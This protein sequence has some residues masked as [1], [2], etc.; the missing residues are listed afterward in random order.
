MQDMLFSNITG[1]S[2][3]G[4]V[5]VGDVNFPIETIALKGLQLELAKLTDFPGGYRDLRPPD[6]P[7]GLEAAAPGA[8][9]VRNVRE[10]V[11]SV[12]IFTPVDAYQVPVNDHYHGLCFGISGPFVR[13]GQFVV[14]TKMLM[15]VDA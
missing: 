8:L 4:V 5:M 15:I 3:A 11:I 2:E 7:E 14:R 9:Y 12:C 13:F 1:V 6:G 10:F